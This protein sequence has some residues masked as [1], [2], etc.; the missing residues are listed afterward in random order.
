[1]KKVSLLLALLAVCLTAVS[2]V[3]TIWAQSGQDN[4]CPTGTEP[5]I[6]N[7][8]EPGY[9]TGLIVNEETGIASWD[10]VPGALANR[11]QWM[12]VEW[13][14]D[15]G[16]PLGDEP[17]QRIEW[18]RRGN[19]V[20]SWTCTGESISTAGVEANT[21][22]DPTASSVEFSLASLPPFEWWFVHVQPITREN[23]G[24][25]SPPAYFKSEPTAAQAP[26]A[27]ATPTPTPTP[28]PA[29]ARRS[30]PIQVS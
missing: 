25:F 15:G 2:I 21:A 7:C 6:S 30:T 20:S 27:T 1:M 9:L 19:A 10:P 24:D 18:E 17:R 3:S 4:D 13:R 11:I 14:E 5:P 29:P 26:I 23:I 22:D 16:P 12:Q 28:T 8:S